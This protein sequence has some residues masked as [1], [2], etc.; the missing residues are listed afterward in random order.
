M[1]QAWL[2]D[3]SH[4]WSRRVLSKALRKRG[5][6]TGRRCISATAFSSSRNSRLRQGSKQHAYHTR[7]MLQ[8]V[9]STVSLLAPANCTALLDF[10]SY[11]GIHKL[12]HGVSR[13]ANV[14]Y[15]AIQICETTIAKVYRSHTSCTFENDRVIEC[16]RFRA[17]LP[18]TVN[19]AAFFSAQL[20]S[21][22]SI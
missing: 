11:I 15:H 19:P 20:V 6:L 18:I 21:G 17:K 7:G 9:S 1:T 8:Y 13:T 2:C 22:K 5:S 14:L 3:V 12:L 16:V 4:L 10:R